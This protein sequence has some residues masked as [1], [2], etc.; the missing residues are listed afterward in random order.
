[1]SAPLA[2]RHP[3]R[4]RS[5][6]LLSLILILASAGILV[7]TS[8]SAMGYLPPMPG[9]SAGP[10]AATSPFGGPASLHLGFMPAGSTCTVTSASNPYRMPED[11]NGQIDLAT[12]SSDGCS[13]GDWAE[14]FS[15]TSVGNPTAG[16][17]RIEVSIG[18]ATRPAADLVRS[19]L[20]AFLRLPISEVLLTLSV[21]VDVGAVF[22]SGGIS[23]NFAFEGPLPVD[24]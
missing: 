7:G 16:L 6:S 24:T 11:G 8:A 15:A 4:A 13:P 18:I 14:V 10:M 2:I 20:T 5:S 21:R 3:G 9:S 23:M 12:N 1:M 22:P 17:Y 19:V